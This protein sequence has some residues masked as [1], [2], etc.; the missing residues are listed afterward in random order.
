MSLHPR[1]FR[2][3]KTFIQNLAPSVFSIQMPRMFGH[4]AW[5][6]LK[7]VLERLPT[8]MNSRIE[9]L[10]PHRWQPRG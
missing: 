3:L 7:D 8:H 5:A 2:S 1:V 10:L 6:Y 4:D 9:E